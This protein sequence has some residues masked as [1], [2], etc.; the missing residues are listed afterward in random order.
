ME[1]SLERTHAKTIKYKMISDHE[2]NEDK[3]LGIHLVISKRRR[4]II[5]F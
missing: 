5:Q 4:I 2:N 3:A 1:N